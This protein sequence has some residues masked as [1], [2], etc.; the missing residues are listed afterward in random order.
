MNRQE[1]ENLPL[2]ISIPHIIYAIYYQVIRNACFSLFYTELFIKINF[3]D[4]SIYTE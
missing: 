4:F 2:K 3:L 1:L